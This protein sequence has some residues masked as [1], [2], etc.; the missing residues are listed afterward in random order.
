MWFWIIHSDIGFVW[1]CKVCQRIRGFANHSLETVAKVNGVPGGWGANS[2]GRQAGQHP[3][4]P[5]LHPSPLPLCSDGHLPPP[6]FFLRMGPGG[7]L[8]AREAECGLLGPQNAFWRPKT[9][10]SSFQPPGGLTRFSCL[11][12][13]VLKAKNCHF[14]GSPSRRPQNTSWGGNEQGDGTPKGTAVLLYQ[15]FGQILSCKPIV[16]FSFLLPRRTIWFDVQTDNC[17]KQP[18]Y[19]KADSERARD[20]SSWKRWC[21]EVN[22]APDLSLWLTIGV[23]LVCILKN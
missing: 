2:L 22:V 15:I 20:H 10:I 5:Q 17:C 3:S 14:C 4:R 11:S 13:C 6:V 21:T 19:S 9:I 1:I 7:P 23:S 18:S 16:C 8:R 12:E